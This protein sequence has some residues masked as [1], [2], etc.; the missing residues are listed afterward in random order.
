MKLVCKSYFLPL[1]EILQS[2]QNKTTSLLME[3]ESFS[4]SSEGKGLVC[5]SPTPAGWLWSQRR[6]AGNNNQGVLVITHYEKQ[7]D[8]AGGGAI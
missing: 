1:S 3:C 5:V 2:T 6:I 4:R 7:Q 8:I